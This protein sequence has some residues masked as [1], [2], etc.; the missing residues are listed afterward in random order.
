M[1]VRAEERPLSLLVCAVCKVH[2]A[3]VYVKGLENTHGK[4]YYEKKKIVPEF[5]L[6]D[7]SK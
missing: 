1:S 6:F 4:A 3:R 5:Q 7:V 2:H